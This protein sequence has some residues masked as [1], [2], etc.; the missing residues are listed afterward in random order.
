LGII[1]EKVQQPKEKKMQEEKAKN[2][3]EKVKET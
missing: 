2:A 1:I 3:G